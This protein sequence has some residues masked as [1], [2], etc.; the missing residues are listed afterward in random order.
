[1]TPEVFKG[2]GVVLITKVG[3]CVRKEKKRFRKEKKVVWWGPRVAHE[4]IEGHGSC[5]KSDNVDGYCKTP[6]CR[7]EKCLSTESECL[8]FVEHCEKTCQESAALKA[9]EDKVI[10]PWIICHK[11]TSY[12]EWDADKV[13]CDGEWEK[14]CSGWT[15]PEGS[16][17]AVWLARRNETLKENYSKIKKKR[18]WIETIIPENVLKK[19]PENRKTHTSTSKL[20]RDGKYKQKGFLAWAKERWC[21]GSLFFGKH[22][23]FG[24]R[25]SGCHVR[26]RRLQTRPSYR[27]TRALIDR[28]TKMG[29]PTED[30][31]RQRQP[32]R[33]D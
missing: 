17:G 8:S 6:D 22:F 13:S 20:F 1:V 18:R 25:R 21:G 3:V 11:P 4:Y 24:G 26:R 33:T 31:E 29:L 9:L 7:G 23:V 28:F 30:P 10:H 5:S 27:D 2:D 15:D 19:I 14:T 32:E 16:T 12:A